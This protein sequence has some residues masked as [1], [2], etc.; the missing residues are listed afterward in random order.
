MNNNIVPFINKRES[1]EISESFR[2]AFIE[3]SARTGIDYNK[4]YGLDSKEKQLEKNKQKVIRRRDKLATWDLD[5][6]Y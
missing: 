1:E 3:K 6:L 4:L 2:Q 5:E